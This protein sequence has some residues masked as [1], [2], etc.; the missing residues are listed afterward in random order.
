MPLTEL[1]TYPCLLCLYLRLLPRTLLPEGSPALQ[2]WRSSAPLLIMGSQEWNTPD[3]AG[4]L[5]C[6]GE[7]QQRVLAAAAGGEREGRGCGYPH[8]PA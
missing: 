7:R 3:A 5:S 8:S 4:K 6:N 1:V 2:G